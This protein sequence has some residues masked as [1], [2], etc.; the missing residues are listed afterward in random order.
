[1]KLCSL[2]LVAACV[3]SFDAFAGD[4]LHP[5]HP[6]NSSAHSSLSPGSPKWFRPGYGYVQPES[7]I[8]QRAQVPYLSLNADAP[9]QG[10]AFRQAQPEER[11]QP[12]FHRASRVWPVPGD[13][14][15]FRMDVLR[16]YGSLPTGVRQSW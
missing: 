16:S 5:Y 11:L 2:T 4:Q 6:S 14:R 8:P 15:G 13:V 3:L 10:Y 9:F 12:T 7:L 1:M